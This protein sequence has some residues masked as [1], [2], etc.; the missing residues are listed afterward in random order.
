[1][2]VGLE[3]ADGVAGLAES[4]LRPLGLDPCGRGRTPARVPLTLEHAGYRTLAFRAG[5]RSRPEREEDQTLSWALTEEER[6]LRDT[7]REFARRGIRPTA[8]ERDEAERFDRGIFAE[9]GA[10]GLAGAPLPESVGGGGFSYL[11]WSLVME[12]IGAADM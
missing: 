8:V 7:A 10:L 6:L 9:M 12:E 1:R 2:Q 3:D 4:L 5:R 11:G